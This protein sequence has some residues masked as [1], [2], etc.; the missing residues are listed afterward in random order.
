MISRLR[1]FFGQA[2]VAV[3]SVDWATEKRRFFFVE[4]NFCVA[5]PAASLHDKGC[6]SNS[7]NAHPRWYP[8]ISG[9]HSFVQKRAVW[10]RIPIGFGPEHRGHANSTRTYACPRC[11][12]FGARE[13]RHAR[14]SPWFGDTQPVFLFEKCAFWRTPRS[15]PTCLRQ[16]FFY[17]FFAKSGTKRFRSDTR[18]TWL[19]R[20]RFFVKKHWR[21]WR[22]PRMPR[23]Y[24]TNSERV[25]L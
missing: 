11:S 25:K 17:V 9:A 23:S 14:L 2:F 8:L 20:A 13:I 19:L 5:C 6:A 18:R 4:E 10:R 15:Y 22:N 21:F 12:F 16:A 1:A 7:R 24:P 3:K